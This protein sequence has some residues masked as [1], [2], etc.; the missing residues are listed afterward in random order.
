M[1]LLRVLIEECS[2]QYG[3]GELDIPIAYGKRS[4]F[5]FDEASGRA[6]R[7]SRMEDGGVDVVGRVDGQDRRRA[8]WSLVRETGC[9]WDGVNAF[10]LL[11]AIRSLWAM[12]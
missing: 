10:T 12:E 11:D 5:L 3:A 6:I 7:I 2:R 9:V 1:E 4:L 8:H